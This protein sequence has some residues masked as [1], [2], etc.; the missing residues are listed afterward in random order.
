MMILEGVL[1]G[2]DGHV[3]H[4]MRASVLIAEKRDQQ[5]FGHMQKLVRAAG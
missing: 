4:D 1:Q 2:V 3:M 5:W